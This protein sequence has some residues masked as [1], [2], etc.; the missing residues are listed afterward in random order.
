MQPEFIHGG[1]PDYACAAALETLD[2]HA[3]VPADA[4]ERPH[5][6]ARATFVELVEGVHG[7]YHHTVNIAYSDCWETEKVF[8]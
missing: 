3:P 6:V 1:H 8:L 5:L 2:A 4:A 7:Q